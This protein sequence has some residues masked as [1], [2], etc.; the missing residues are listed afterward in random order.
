MEYE[1]NKNTLA[2]IPVSDE[3]S[4]ILEI[5]NEYIVKEKSFK[6]IE[7][8]CKYFGSS[9]E[10]RFQGTKSLIGV[11]HKSPIVI[12]ESS[13]LI[14]FPTASPL[15][16]NC[17]WISLNNIKNY[18]PGNNFDSSII[19][20][21]N[22]EKIELDMSYGSLNNQILRATRLKVVLIDRINKN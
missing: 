6:V 13:K 12:E 9:Y 7:E 20:F 4:K 8:S 18:F 19:E 16:N 14:F 10:G 3:K 5:E 17:K 22:G 15:R 21:I 11:T 1:I 2:I